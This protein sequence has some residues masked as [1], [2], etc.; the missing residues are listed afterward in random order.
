[1][2][3]CLTCKHYSYKHLT[4]V[5]PARRLFTSSPMATH[6]LRPASDRLSK[7]LAASSAFLAVNSAY[8]A[9]FAT[10]SLF[11]YSNVA[12]HVIVGVV[13]AI[14][15]A[16]WL[17]RRL[18]GLGPAE[19]LAAL[20]LVAGTALGVALTITGALTRYRWLLLAHITVVSA[21][22]VL[23]LAI[24]AARLGPQVRGR[25]R[26][27]HAIAVVLLLAAAG[28]STAMVLR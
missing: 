9:A 6:D 1:M 13:W 20:L 27:A 14:A 3:D 16:I 23:A 10:A 4:G 8:L 18:R 22:A 25:L 26:P 24:V 11:Y 15:G 19:R 21:G 5:W 7:L 12:L 17:R 28:W 2:S